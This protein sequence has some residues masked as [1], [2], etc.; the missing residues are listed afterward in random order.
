M[1]TT[2]DFYRMRLWEKDHW[3]YR[4]D[5]SILNLQNNTISFVMDRT[6]LGGDIQN[7][8][9]FIQPELMMEGLSGFGV[10]DSSKAPIPIVKGQT[11]SVG[12]NPGEIAPG[13]Y[14]VLLEADARENAYAGMFA[15]F[16]V[17]YS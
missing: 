8:N 10:P 16:R 12:S 2:M 1:A 11:Y 17:T 5:D 3:V 4:Q 6:S 14:V 9:V 15:H 7:F 13:H